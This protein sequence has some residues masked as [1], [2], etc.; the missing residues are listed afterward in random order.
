MCNQTNSR[1]CKVGTSRRKKPENF[2][3]RLFTGQIAAETSQ[4]FT[5]SSFH[6]EPCPR[7]W[8]QCAQCKDLAKI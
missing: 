3:E 4:K 8:Y 5:I 1:R 7:T 2:D 6:Q